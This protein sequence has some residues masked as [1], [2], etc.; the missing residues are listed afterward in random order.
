MVLCGG[1]CPTSGSLVQVLLESGE[2]PPNILRITSQIYYVLSQI[3]YIPGFAW[4]FEA[5]PW[6]FEGLPWIFGYLGG[7]L[8]PRIF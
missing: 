8:V 2:Y 1:A 4:I 6:I 3:S 7:S 5:V